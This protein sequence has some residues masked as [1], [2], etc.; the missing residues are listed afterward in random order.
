MRVLYIPLDMSAAERAAWAWLTAQADIASVRA[1]AGDA[2]RMARLTRADVVWIDATF[3]VSIA[4]PGI[5]ELAASDGAGWLLTNGAVTLPHRLGIERHAPDVYIDRAWRDEEDELFFFDT[6]AET[7]RLRGHAAFRHHSL[8]TGLGSGAYTWWP[9]AGESY[10]AV[11]YDRPDGPANARVIAVERAFIHVNEN[12]VT[13][14][15]Y[16]MPRPILCIGAYM[17]FDA[18]DTIFPRIRER[19]ARNALAWPTR[20]LDTTADLY[21]HAGEV[22]VRRLDIPRTED[23]FPSGPLPITPLSPLPLGLAPLRADARAGAPF[24]LA[25]RRA[26]IAG[27]IGESREVW[28]HPLRVMQIDASPSRESSATVSTLGIEQRTV[29][30]DSTVTERFAVMHDRAAVVF[31]WDSGPVV[32]EWRTDLRLMWPYPA[33]ALGSLEW[34]TTSRSLVIRSSHTGERVTF[35]TSADVEW[36]VVDATANGAPAL[37]CGLRSPASHALRLTVTAGSHDDESL[38]GGSRPVDPADGI[39][40]RAAALRRIAHEQLRVD[41]PDPEIDSALEWAKLRLD[42]YLVET[43][44]VGRSLVAGYWTSRPGWNDA[45]PGYAWY[46][47][48]DAAWTALASLAVGDFAAVRDTIEFLGAHQ[49]LSGKILHECTTSGSVHY[50]AADS[51]PL[52][53]LLV[54]RFLAWSGDVSFLRAQLPRI[55][56]ALAFCISTDTDGDG[57]IENTRVGHGWIE[58]GQ[59]GGGKVTYYNA[60]I[61]A[62]A[63]RELG[64]AFEDI[65]A[66]DLAHQTRD[67]SRLAR[68][69]LERLFYSAP[70]RAY[71]LKAWNPPTD[72]E[73]D[74]DSVRLGG[75]D[76]CRDFTPTATHAVPLLLGVADPDRARSWLD[77]VAS[78]DFS[79]EWGV[80]MIARSDPA[81]D[82][83]SYHGGA[84][85]PLYTGWTS[86]AEYSAGRA[87]SAF[88]HWRANVLLAFENEPGAWDEVLHGTDRRSIGVCPDQA[89]STAMAVCPLVYGLLGAEPDAP[90]GRI[91]LRPQIPR[92]WDRLDLRNLRIADA[93]LSFCY[94]HGND[95]HTFTIE[96]DEGAVPLRVIFEPALP[97]SSISAV[98][99]DGIEARLDS[100]AFGSRLLVPAQ[101]MLDHARTIEIVAA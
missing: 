22:G 73:P 98:R 28:I 90:R 39:R 47:G 37:H 94:R 97:A 61:W 57:L 38:D 74:P 54:A 56:N 82:P 31:E 29:F 25:G 92:H 50:D 69:A 26:L 78:S 99:I 4:P 63:L 13:V 48:R 71:A 53:L 46:F 52:Y 3:P 67:L 70:L 77:R 51:T 66:H 59:L 89:W 93:T 87:D 6:F 91:R 60:G 9:A 34:W 2:A 44:G 62:A 24:T 95:T 15:A 21:W 86:W 58:F 45:R 49:D 40:A 43:P 16:E 8:F 18:Q 14:W 20:R 75:L 84:V 68:T 64:T 72:A 33:G 55:R 88:Q 85:W 1:N 65:G 5:G 81:F 100:R 10:R 17:P 35:G 23:S 80:R 41:T 83:S 32:L 36:S 30:D 96:Q 7:P 27:M 42:D 11:M 19:F 79:A 76:W 12:R 101:V